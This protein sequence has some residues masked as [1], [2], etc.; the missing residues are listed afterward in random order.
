[1]PDSPGK[2]SWLGLTTLVPGTPMAPEIGSVLGV[3]GL[4]VVVSRGT[5]MGADL[6]HHNRYSRLAQTQGHSSA[7]SHGR[8]TVPNEPGAG[9]LLAS[10]AGAGVLFMTGAG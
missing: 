2:L 1:M 8:D 6:T 3:V 5:P 9:A 4:L 7:V 10:G